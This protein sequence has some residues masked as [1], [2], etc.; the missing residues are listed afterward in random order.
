MTDRSRLDRQFLF[1][2]MRS[3]EFQRQWTV[4]KGD[5]DMADYV[6]LTAQRTLLVPVPSMSTQ[7][8]I[9]AIV[10]AYDER[11]ENN[12][13]R[14]NILEEMTQR[15]YR[16]WFID[17]RY[18]GHERVLLVDSEFGPMP[19]GW[20]IGTMGDLVDVNA[21]TIRKI[22]QGESIHYIDIASVQRGEIQATRKMLLAEAPGRARRRV[23]DGDILW[24][25]VRPNLR[26]HALVLS[27]DKDCVASTGFAVLSPRRASFAYVYALTTTD[28]FVEYLSGRAT[29]S[30]YPAVTPGVFEAA[31]IVVPHRRVIDEFATLCEPPL[32]LASRLRVQSAT[33][34]ATRDLLLPRL[35]SGQ[36]DVTDLDVATADAAA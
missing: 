31:P 24:S 33:L 21:A 27:P 9:A 25:T 17:F 22:E 26:G 35:I 36:I 14:I 19:D 23:A 28:D 30:A 16:E 34:S 18:P 29:G 3:P 11:I 5:T 10:T 20:K 4:R 7:R 1:A 15:I 8:K 32:R 2:Y 13:R 12:R 6:S